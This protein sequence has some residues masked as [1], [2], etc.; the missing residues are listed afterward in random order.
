MRK[1]RNT[2]REERIVRMPK[3]PKK[4]KKILRRK[5]RFQLKNL[6]S[7]RNSSKSLR[8]KKFNIKLLILPMFFLLFLGIMFLALRY[9]LRLRG[10]ITEG[11][12]HEITQILG[13]DNIPSLEGST[14]LFA[15]NLDSPIVKEF[16]S[17]GNSVYILPK[18]KS[19]KDVE[20]Y[21]LD[22]L[23]KLGWEYIESV[24]IGTV[25]KK[26]G[27]YWVKDG[28]GLRI[29]TKFNNIWYETITE[30]DARTALS[31][32]V[33]EEIER[34]MLMASSDKQSL[35]PDFPWVLD[36]PKEYLIKY[37]PTQLKELRA[38]TFQKIGSEESIE[39][40]PLGR[41]KERDLDAY[42][43][44]YCTLKTTEE[45]KYGVLNSVPISF[46]ETLG[47]KS[48]VQI[49]S[50]N[51]TAYTVANSYN[52]MVYVILSSNPNSPLLEYIIDNIK[53]SNTKD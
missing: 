17:G 23:K 13:L 45:V 8:R 41:W 24:A 9:V 20:N 40:Y 31:R 39:I 53:P 30:D 5:K 26:Y 10:D 1:K 4:E 6:F 7:K 14:F 11:K 46:R 25:D 22:K 42:L 43:F 27:Q 35:L 51:A 50:E 38:V 2:N 29:Y 36:I 44:D 15:D 48:T 32:L 18:G 16:L 21:Y 37:S 28:K 47:L 19:S 52:S 49:G 34:E 3:A 33:Q 12:E